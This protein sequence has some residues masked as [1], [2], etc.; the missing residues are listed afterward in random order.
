VTISILDFEYLPLIDKMHS[1]FHLI[2]DE[3]RKRLTDILELHVIELPKLYKQLIDTKDE[4]KLK[5]WMQ[6]VESEDEEV[7]QML[8]AKDEKIKK[9]YTVLTTISQDENERQEYESREMQLYDEIS[10]L[11]DAKEEGFVKGSK[12]GFEKG[13]KNKAIDMAKAMLLANEPIEK[14]KSYT[15]LSE[16]EI[17]ILMAYEGTNNI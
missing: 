5:D 12:E 10:R 11:D 16:Q 2:E 1:T 6:F 3:T 14:I 17:K 9:A 13:E 8:A 15:K 4:S 7:L